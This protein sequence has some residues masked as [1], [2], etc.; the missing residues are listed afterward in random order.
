MRR[1]Y[2]ES[3]DISWGEVTTALLTLGIMTFLLLV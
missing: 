2:R 1:E 3:V